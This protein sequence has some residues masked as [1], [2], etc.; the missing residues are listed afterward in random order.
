MTDDLEFREYIPECPWCK[1]T[2]PS[3][4][5]R[6][7]CNECE[8]CFCSEECRAAAHAEH[9]AEAAHDYNKPLEE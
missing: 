7:S 1:K 2:F 8:C 3:N 6:P 9:R 5:P 4:E